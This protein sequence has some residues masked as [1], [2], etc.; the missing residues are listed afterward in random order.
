ML[1][2]ISSL[3]HFVRFTVQLNEF[4]H[5]P[6]VTALDTDLCS[7]SDAQKL[8]ISDI[9]CQ[10]FEVECDGS[11]DYILAHDTGVFFSL[12]YITAHRALRKSS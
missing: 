1:G 7:L 11:N 12:K 3:H 10:A 6:S 9:G 4:Q 8:H 5:V 2:F